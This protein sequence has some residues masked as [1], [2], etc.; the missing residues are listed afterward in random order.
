MWSAS[1]YDKS[2]DGR[3]LVKDSD[4]DSPDDQSLLGALRLILRDVINET[5]GDQLA[6]WLGVILE[7]H[8][9]YGGVPRFEDVLSTV[10]AFKVSST[11]RRGT[12]K[13]AKGSGGD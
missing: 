4:S 12:T 3:F 5:S 11:P 1:H 13:K 2:I 7:C 6:D 10:K 9:F 8:M